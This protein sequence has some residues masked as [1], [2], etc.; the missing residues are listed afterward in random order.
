MKWGPQPSAE[1]KLFSKG[2]PGKAAAS[3][4]L[5]VGRNTEVPGF[6]VICCFHQ[7]SPTGRIW[8]SDWT[9]GMGMAGGQAQRL[10]WK[11]LRGAEA[12]RGGPVYASGLGVPA[13]GVTHC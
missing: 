4:A 8:N 9:G 7:Q 11:R 5:A 12:S 2:V 13:E 1:G 3:S 6:Q 10:L